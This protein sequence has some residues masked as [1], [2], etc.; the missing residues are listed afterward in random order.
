[1]QLTYP[2]K[3][4]F[5]SRKGTGTGLIVGVMNRRGGKRE[6]VVGAAEKAKPGDVFERVASCSRTRELG[7]SAV[8]LF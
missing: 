7:A 4:R 2:S 8:W 3:W 5:P 1:M 6:R